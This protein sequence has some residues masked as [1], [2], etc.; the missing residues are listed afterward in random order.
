MKIAIKINY[1]QKVDHNINHTSRAID[2]IAYLLA[3]ELVKRKHEVTVFVTSDSETSA[4]IAVNSLD[5]REEDIKLCVK[6]AITRISKIQPKLKQKQLRSLYQKYLK[7]SH[8]NIVNQAKSFDIIHTHDFG[9]SFAKYVYK[10]PIPVVSTLHGAGMKYKDIAPNHFF[11]A[12][13]N[14]QK[15][16]YPSLPIIGV[17]HNGIK[18]E[19]FEFSEKA[20]DYMIFLGRITPD[21][22]ILEAIQIVNKTHK[23]LK[24]AGIIDQN[25]PDYVRKITKEIESNKE[26][27]FLG[28]VEQREKSSLLKG[29]LAVL[30]PIQ[31]EEPFGLVAV[32]ALACGTPVIAFA[33]G[34]LPEIIKD[35]RTGFIINP[36]DDDIRGDYITKK[37]GIDGFCEA[38]KH[39]YSLSKNDYLKMRRASRKHVEEQFALKRMVDGYEKIYSELVR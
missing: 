24:I 27:Q 23:K 9:V 30:M 18:I 31:W 4:R 34:A 5:S 19:D 39:I 25:V 6:Y 37:T 7:K 2:A 20:E 38:I 36:S 10:I 14:A 12:I 13:S 15:L 8:L 3:E 1:F 21:K 28:E 32:E 29:A 35:G 16:L 22:G 26:I 33:R 17:V 11:M